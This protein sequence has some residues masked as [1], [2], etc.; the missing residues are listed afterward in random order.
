MPIEQLWENFYEK[1]YG[2]LVLT[3]DDSALD[4][5]YLAVLAFGYQD[6]EGAASYA[7][8]ASERDPSDLVFKEAATYLQRTQKEGK[9]NVYVTPE[10]FGAF[11][12]GGGN[13]G[14]YQSTSD[15]LRSVYQE[16]SGVKLLDIGVGDGLALLPALTESVKSVTLVEPSAAMLAVVSRELAERGVQHDAVNTTLQD[17][18]LTENG[19]WD[20]AQ[21]TYSLQ[22]IPPDERPSLFRWLRAHC[23]RALVVE[24][25]P[26][27][28]NGM[29]SPDRVRYVHQ[30]YQ[31]GL[32]E[33]ANDGSLV[34]Q[35]FLMPV[36]FGY[37]D[38]S[39]ARTN[40]EQPIEDWINAFGDAGFEQV[41]KRLLF[42]YWWATAYIIDAK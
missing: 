32:A 42:D 1:G 28:F 9:Q 19:E 11:I 8:R 10:A 15:A 12:R 7:Q 39:A 21:A 26:P 36:M 2:S 40:Y 5:F 35:G 18:V 23:K 41:E 37:F 25:D 38:Q 27:H 31:R 24:F 22:G 3:D 14:L 4:H 34:A 30:R 33:Y 6:L 13:I 16:Y 20:L 29:Y 17:F